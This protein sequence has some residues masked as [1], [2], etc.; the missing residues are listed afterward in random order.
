MAAVLAVARQERLGGNAASLAFDA[1]DAF[2]ALVVSSYAAFTSFGTG[3]G[4]ATAP[5]ADGSRSGRAP[6]S[7]NDRVSIR[8]G[9][10]KLSFSYVLFVL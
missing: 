3:N 2:V 7:S 10:E 6:D 4:P 1:F 5:D 9:D 8:L